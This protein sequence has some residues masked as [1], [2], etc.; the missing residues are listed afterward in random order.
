MISKVEANKNSVNFGAMQLSQFQGIDKYCA[1]TFNAPLEKFNTN[2][3]LQ[4]WAAAKLQTDVFS[5]NLEG[6]TPRATIERNAVLKNWQNYF[7][8]TM[9]LPKTAALVI[10]SA[11]FGNLT[12]KT[13]DV[14]PPSNAQA[15][16]ETF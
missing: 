14:P 10:F 1:K 13:K 12:T 8:Q 7:N 6:K 4:S 16:D 2:N 3:D 5:K 11:L 15:L 9:S